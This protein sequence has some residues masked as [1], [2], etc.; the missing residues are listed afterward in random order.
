MG[1]DMFVFAPPVGDTRICL[2]EVKTAVRMVLPFRH[3][4]M[5]GIRAMVELDK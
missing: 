1:N 3:G 2:A 4:S 5:G